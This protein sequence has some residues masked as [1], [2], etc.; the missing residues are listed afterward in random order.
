MTNRR[1]DHYFNFFDSTIDFNLSIYFFGLNK[2]NSK[3]EK[4]KE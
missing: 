4:K 3:N 2:F 1:H